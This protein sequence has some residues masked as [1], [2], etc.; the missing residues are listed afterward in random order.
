MDLRTIGEGLEAEGY[1]DEDG[2]AN[3]E[4]FWAD[5]ALCWDNCM[6]YYDDDLE[7]EACVMAKAMAEAAEKLE[8]DFW[9]ELETFEKNLETVDPTLGGVAAAMDVA[10]GAVEDMASVAYDVVGNWFKT[11]NKDNAEEAK[12][13][14]ENASGNAT[15]VVKKLCFGEPD[16]QNY[17]VE[18]DP[19]AVATPMDYQFYRAP[20]RP[21]REYFGEIMLLRYKHTAT[22]DLQDIDSKISTA[23]SSACKQLDEKDDDG[24]F[25][26][27]RQKIPLARLF[28]GLS[29]T[30]RAKQKAA[31]KERA[32]TASG[33]SASPKAKGKRKPR[34]GSGQVGKDGNSDASSARSTS[35][36]ASSVASA[37]SASRWRKNKRTSEAGTS[38]SSRRSSVG[39]VRVPGGAMATDRRPSA[40]T[41]ATSGESSRRR[42]SVASNVS[43]ASK[44]SAAT[45]QRSKKKT[46][47]L[48]DD[49][50][51]KK[52]MLMSGD[53]TMDDDV[54]KPMATLQTSV[55]VSKL[56]NIIVKRRA[57]AKVEP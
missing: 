20:P 53:T 18:Y 11:L 55:N 56:A 49:A 23:V 21:L 44:V 17:D 1:D 25:D 26:G 45:K 52:A 14:E 29:K 43:N 5:T 28:P 33:I 22:K 51:L 54:C 30:S 9:L 46:N 15:E 34:H 31:P 4:L 50:R 8:D 2:L 10:A 37:R 19:D 41:N 48:K 39:S 42:S 3:P 47:D 27:V 36:R 57:K 40:D 6:K 35:S 32:S 13:L 7:L 38:G 12:K 16:I 24:E